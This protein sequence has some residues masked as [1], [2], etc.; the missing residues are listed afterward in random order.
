MLANLQNWARHRVPG[1]ALLVLLSTAA[2]AQQQ[3]LLRGIVAD[4]ASGEKLL[5]ATVRLAGAPGAGTT[6]DLDGAFV[7]P[8]VAGR[9][10]TLVVSYVGYR[11]WRRP[12]TAMPAAPL[13]VRL[14]PGQ[15]QT[16]AQV[17]VTA[18]RPIAEDFIVHELNYLQIVTNPAAA[19]DPLL[20]VRTLPAA[21]NPD[22]SASIGLRGSDPSQTGIYLNN[23]P[24]YDAV[25]FA[26]LSG[27]GTFGIFS[28]DLVRSVLVFP[29]NPPLEFGNAGAGLISLSTDEQ[30][31]ARFLQA[32][33][34]LAN[35][36]LLGGVPVGR[37]GMLKAYANGQAGPLLRAVNPAAFR[38]LARL[39]SVDG[40]VHLATKIG[41][42]GTLKAFVYGIAEQYAYRVQD[43]PLPDNRYRY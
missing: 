10:D 8:M 13:R 35:L 7:L 5:G 25:K 4:H 19:A 18:Q 41:P 12:L 26:Q 1:L 42:H 34:G 32:S 43:G 21:T 36:G 11:P 30:P 20:A 28:A 22:E 24:I 38:Q 23:V 16:L 17:E 40:G 14:V 33:V 37:R 9:A 31:R 15:V 6:T 2:Q 27:L 39:G 3:Q 29:S